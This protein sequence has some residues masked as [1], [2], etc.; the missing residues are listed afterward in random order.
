MP[1]G[2]MQPPGG[3]QGGQQQG[4]GWQTPGQGPLDWRVAIQA[5]QRAN[6]DAPPNVLAAA[7]DGMLP[8]MTLQSQ[9]QW[10]EQSLMV[11]EWAQMERDRHN[12][13]TEGMGWDRTG[14]GQ[15]RIDATAGKEAKKTT[16]AQ[17]IGDAIIR[18]EQ[19]PV[20]TGLWR[21]GPD[22]KAYLASKGFDQSKAISEWNGAQ[23]AVRGWNS[24]RMI[25][26]RGLAQSV[27]STIDEVRSLSEQ[28]QQ[29]GLTSWNKIR[30]LAL[31]KGASNTA[32]GQQAISYVTAV[33]TLKS[34][35]AQLENG[36]YAPTEEVWK[37]ANQQISS[38]YGV[39]GMDASLD[40]IQKL[41][42]FRTKAIEEVT[43]AGGSNRYQ[44]RSEQP[45]SETPKQ[46]PG[47]SQFQERFE[48]I[49]EGWSVQEH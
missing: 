43:G 13:E 26:Y 7:V 25:Q 39:K 37:L 1:G 48:G 15:Q 17:E 27:T 30:K 49:P 44:G 42:N 34:E 18:G 35:F 45:T 22:V 10:R 38:D 33:N 4:G 32:A 24:Q 3:Q 31:T 40:E 5:I 16:E 28:L 12:R 8:M 46:K 21:V 14:Q 47:K 6:P 29:N 36:G 9:Q 2:G 23:A 20:T 11:R 19:P 41:I